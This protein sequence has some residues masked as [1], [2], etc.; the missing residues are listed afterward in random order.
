V[1][2]RVSLVKFFKEAIN[3]KGYVYAADCVPT[4]P[5]LYV[6]DKSFLVPK[7]TDKEYIPFL[8]EKC[9]EEKIKLIIPLI[10]T[11]LPILAQEKE[12]FHENGI[13]IL[14]PPLE[15][16]MICHD[17][18]L[19]Y[20]FLLENNLPT[21]KTLLVN[22]ALAEDNLNFPLIIKPR[23]GS[24]S[25]GVQKCENYEDVKFYAKKIFEPILQEFLEGDE[26][27]LDILCDFDGNPISIVPRKR[28]KI[29]GGEVERGIT[30]KN[31]E[32]LSLTLELV[33]KLNPSGVINVQCFLTSKGFY[34]TE[35]NPRF[36]GGYPLTHYAG[37]NFPKLIIKLIEGEK[38][39]PMIGKYKENV[40]MLRYDE[41]IF[42]NE[43][44]L[45]K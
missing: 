28:L 45:I 10:D 32:L 25:I 24:A 29:R 20:R 8:L 17:K 12:K 3:G 42:I 21:P 7:S 23:Y 14:V 1:G 40:L 18:Y 11:E 22:E 30:I 9:V 26:I 33:K 38:I 2:R 39:E 27:T 31:Y 34:F 41:A 37:V 36:G 5:G 44:E 19:T 15:T 6:A 35:I 16:V 13:I 43:S 4:A